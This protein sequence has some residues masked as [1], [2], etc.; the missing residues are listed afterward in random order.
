MPAITAAVSTETK[1]K[2]N[3]VAHARDTTPSRLA[4]SLVEL[5]LSEQVGRGPAPYKSGLQ[6]TAAANANGEA[7]TEQV[8]V[9]LEPYYY[10]E[11]GRLAAERN[12]Y[13]GTYLA[14]LFHAHADRKP[15]LCEVEINALRQVARQLADMGRN[16]NQIAKKL[17]TSLD[18]AQLVTSFD[19]DLVQMLIEVETNAV[20]DVLR[21]NI[22]GW[23][24]SDVET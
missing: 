4:A 6:L 19:F 21:A 10:A 17:N 9:R 13:R 22:R 16:I 7:R 8:F 24:I 18:N 1:T 2:F 15:V 14:N 3:A 5:F 11:L 20:K 12:W 23:G